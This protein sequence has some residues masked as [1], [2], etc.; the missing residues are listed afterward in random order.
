MREAGLSQ[1]RW[2]GLS[3]GM[4]TIHV[5]T[6]IDGDA[7]VPGMALDGGRDRARGAGSRRGPLATR[8]SRSACGSQGG[9]RC[10]PREREMLPVEKRR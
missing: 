10:T 4:V 9:H 6:R 8:P 1:V 5:G 2:F 3:G 7:D